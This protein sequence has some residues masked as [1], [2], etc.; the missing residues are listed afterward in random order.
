MY[1]ICGCLSITECSVVASGQPHHN[2]GSLT[3][4]SPSQPL[5]RKP[6]V[7]LDADEHVRN[8]ARWLFFG[9]RCSRQRKVLLFAL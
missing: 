1:L 8:Y 9:P 6:N 2:K 7:N 5:H 3:T 4:C